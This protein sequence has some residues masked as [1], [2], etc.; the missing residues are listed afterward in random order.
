MTSI[1]W[2]RGPRLRREGCEA[3]LIGLCV[4]QKE[5]FSWGWTEHLFYPQTKRCS[6]EWSLFVN[7]S[8]GIRLNWIKEGRR[9]QVTLPHLGPMGW[10]WGL[11]PTLLCIW[12]IWPFREEWLQ[13]WWMV[14]GY[15]DQEREGNV[16]FSMFSCFSLLL[17]PGSNWSKRS[18]NVL[19]YAWLCG[20]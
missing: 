4:V 12:S 16:L 17:G 18:W 3:W 13:P 7:A 14:G 8:K 5:D 9:R 10:L 20:K 11:S 2:V 6:Q 15:R 1:R 19:S